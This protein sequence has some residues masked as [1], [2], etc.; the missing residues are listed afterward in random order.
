[1]EIQGFSNYLIY[2]DGR[3]FSKRRNKFMKIKTTKNGYKRIGL[4]NNNQYFK[5][6]HRLVAEAFIPNPD[7]KPCVDHIDRV[8]TNNHISNL[9]W[10]TYS[11][12]SQNL[13]D[14]KTNTSGHKYISKIKYGWVFRKNINGIKHTKGFNTL[15]EAI[16]YKKEYLT[17]S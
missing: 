9:R 3:V 11:E 4:R 5:L 15:E 1:M 14:I 2:P 13:G 12:N 16:E 6:V 17:T 8:R 10:V 7:N